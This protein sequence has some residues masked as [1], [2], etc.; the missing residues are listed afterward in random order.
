M[1]KSMKIYFKVFDLAQLGVE[2]K[3]VRRINKTHVTIQVIENF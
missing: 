2:R 1:P 3:Q